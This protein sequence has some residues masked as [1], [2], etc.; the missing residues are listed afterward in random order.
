MALWIL[1]TWCMYD[2]K[3]D[4]RSH[5]RLETFKKRDCTEKKISFIK[6]NKIMITVIHYKEMQDLSS[7]NYIN[8]NI[9]H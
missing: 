4:H 9:S 8:Q 7:G 2:A 3:V 6:T 1:L 5:I